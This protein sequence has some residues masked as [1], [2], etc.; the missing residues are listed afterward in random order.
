MPKQTLALPQLESH[1]WE[2]A[3]ILRGPV[4][5]ADFKTYIFPLLFFK[6]ICDDE[7]QEI[8]D[9]TGDEQ[10]ACFPESHRFQIPE[11]C[12]W[13]DVRGHATNVGTALQHAMRD[14][15]KA[16]PDA[17]Y[18]VFGD[19][20]WSNKD[21]LSDALLKDLIEHFSKLP[22]GSH[23]VTSD[24]LGD[25]YEYL[26]KKFADATNKKAGEFYT[27]RSI[28]RVM[29]DILDPKEGET[30]YD[31]A[32]G[33]GGMLLAAVQHV[34][35]MHGDVKL[36]WGKLFGQEK[37]LTP[38][39]IAR[40]NLFRHGIEDFQIV[41]GDTLRNPAF[42]DGD[43]LANFDCV[44]ANPPFSLENWGEEQWQ[45]D[46]FGRNFAGL[47]PASSG[48]FAWVQH[49]VKSMTDGTGR[50]AVVLPQ[51][52]LFRKGA[53]GAIRQKLLE[54]D[55]VEAVIGLAPNLFY[56]TGLAACILV[57]RK[58]KPAARK[59]KVLIADASRLFRR[60]RAQNYL[61]PEQAAEI[62]GWYRSFADVADAVRIVSLDEIKAEDWTLNI[63]RYVLPPLQED[64]PPLPEA[65]A[66]FKE[67]LANCRV[68]E[69]RLAKVMTEGGWLL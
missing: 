62:L 6:R 69:D 19:A 10:L 22:L 4:D 28:V 43:R 5:A 3:N 46:P 55:L 42:F 56:G 9:D 24:M 61:E 37:N 68:A 48:D 40:L 36:L 52:A 39:S 57:L 25:A 11:D 45:S 30:I 20:Q 17:L 67:A 47:P 41:R 13:N 38:S 51:G 12:H 21:R 34:K 33:T 35:E 59:K 60:G 15:E 27:P 58:R 16:N 50:M 63:S 29:I 1:L 31:P 44:I 18:G 64:I 26:I 65:I 2:S 23:N 14:I 66:A 8:V 7:Y 54:M 49:M 53:E 32:C